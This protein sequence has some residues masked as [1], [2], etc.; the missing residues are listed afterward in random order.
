MDAQACPMEIIKVHLHHNSSVP[1]LLHSLYLHHHLACLRDRHLLRLGMAVPKAFCLQ[2]SIL[3]SKASPPVL[4]H[5]PDL[6]LL[7][8]CLLFSSRQGLEEGDGGSLNE[9]R[10]RQQLSEQRTRKEIRLLLVVLGP[11]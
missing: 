8:G 11:K 10:S 5:L 2:D 3:L 6:V 9:H 4:R 1:H 7:P